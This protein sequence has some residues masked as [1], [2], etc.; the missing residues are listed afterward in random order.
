MP[1]T[2]SPS[3]P[4]RRAAWLR[5]A[6]FVAALVA[7]AIVFRKPLFEGNFGVVDPGRV[8]RSAQPGN[9]LAKTIGRESLGAIVNL[10]GGSDSDPFYR[11]EVE[12]AERLGV[13]FYDI[14][15]GANHRPSRRD[16]M[17]VLAVLDQCRYPILIHCKW[18]ADR[19]GLMSALYRL[20]K[21][22]EPPDRAVAEFTVAHSHFPIFGPEHLHEPFDEY[23][24]WL[25]QRSLPHDSARFRSW[26]ER[27]Y[28]SD[29]PFRG[30]PIV[31]SGPRP[32]DAALAPPA[33]NR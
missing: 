22:G 24:A 21:L 17:R 3:I 5:R 27:E 14:P 1:A 12:T 18:G 16:L 7:A 25:R 11:H 19:T 20:D 8:Y 2:K 26:L 10:R 23:A 6:I 29:D 28:R 32:V 13:E 30:W 4:S 15:M 31:R 9:G 33:A